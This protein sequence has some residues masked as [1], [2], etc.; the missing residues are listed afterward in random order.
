MIGRLGRDLGFELG[1][2]AGLARHLG[3]IEG[4]AHAGDG[5]G[6]ALVGRHQAERL[7][8][9]RRIASLEV[10]SGE[11]SQRRDVLRVLLQDGGIDLGGGLQVACF[12]RLVGRFDGCGGIHRRLLAQ[13]ALDERLDG[14]FGL[15][16]LETV[17]RAA[18][19]EGIDGGD[20]LDAQLVGQRL[21]LVDIDLDELDLAPVRTDDL[22]EQWC[23]LLARP[24]PRRPEID[25]HWHRT[26]GFE[27]VLGEGRRGR[28]LDH[29]AAASRRFR[30][31]R[32]A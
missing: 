20:R 17:E 30:C 5:A 12:Q 21:V 4:R 19:A 24:A 8:G 31:A 16:A 22:L 1:R 6:V 28:I 23:E 25:Q 29:V 15:R 3:E 9:A 26:R 7:L 18:V 2:I 27:H 11:T 10:A 14:A 13:Q 32:F